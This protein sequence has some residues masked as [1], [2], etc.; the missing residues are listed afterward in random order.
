MGSICYSW[1]DTPYK[2]IETPFTWAE[3]CVIQKII[4][5]LG[6]GPPKKGLVRTRDRQRRG[7]KGEVKKQ[8]DKLEDEEKLTLVNLF[9]RLQT[10]QIVIETRINKHKNTKVKIKLRDI[11]IDMMEQKNISVSVKNVI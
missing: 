3:G 8:I 7:T 10:D 1:D 2:W 5:G 6:G 4:S 9:V 11:K